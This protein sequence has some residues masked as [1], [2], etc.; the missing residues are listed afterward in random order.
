MDMNNS[1]ISRV[2]RNHGVEHATLHILAQRY[3]N[4]PIAGHSD[5]NGFWILG[6]VPLEVVAQAS[7]EAI[8][9]LQ[10]GERHLAVH[11]N[12]GTNFVTSG[13]LAGAAAFFSLFGAGNRTRD[14]LERLPLAA[15]LATLAL[16]LSRPLGLM[17]Q[18]RFT[19]SGDPD[20]LAIHEVR[21]AKRGSICAHRVITG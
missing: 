14:K 4:L 17:I 7:Q 11:A 21:R 13:V 19:T 9:R 18:E 8:S 5:G 1:Y 12:C 16:I 20:G 6:D 2:R 15:S 10:N 3:P